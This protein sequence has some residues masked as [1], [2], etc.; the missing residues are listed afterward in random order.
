[1]VWTSSSFIAAWSTAPFSGLAAF[2]G[3]FL[4][5]FCGFGWIATAAAED[6]ILVRGSVGASE[7]ASERSIEDDDCGWL[8]DVEQEQDNLGS[9]GDLD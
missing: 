4:V 1:M 7:R 3:F 9:G 8:D 6:R 2:T 5:G